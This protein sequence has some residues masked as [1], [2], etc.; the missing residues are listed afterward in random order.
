L[1]CSQSCESFISDWMGMIL[2]TSL[3][4]QIKGNSE[5]ND[6]SRNSWLSLKLSWTLPKPV[7]PSLHYTHTEL[8]FL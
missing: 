4:V 6:F 5:K 8:G 7:Y 2:I 1:R 3:I